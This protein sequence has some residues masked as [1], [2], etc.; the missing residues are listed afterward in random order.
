MCEEKRNIFANILLCDN[1]CCCH[2]QLN[3]YVVAVAVTQFCAFDFFVV[4][5][6]LHLFFCFSAFM[7]VLLSS[8]TMGNMD[9]TNDNNN[10]S[11]HLQWCPPAAA[12]ATATATAYPNEFAS[13]WTTNK[14]FVCR[15]CFYFAYSLTLFFFRRRRRMHVKFLR[16]W[17]TIMI[18]VTSCPE[19]ATSKLTVP[20][21]WCVT[22]T[23]ATRT[24]LSDSMDGWLDDG[25]MYI[26][27]NVRSN[28]RERERRG[29]HIVNKYLVF[30]KNVDNLLALL[31][32][33]FF[34]LLV[35]VCTAMYF[36]LVLVLFTLTLLC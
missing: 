32:L 29:R 33:L 31:L 24:L 14:R 27:R 2:M 13:L 16:K 19:V 5:L 26:C 36:V 10:S 9:D 25:G 8:H 12:A 20:L 21:V 4:L 34:L 6:F 28:S 1:S 17:I 18:N 30:Y 7:V 23:A 35:F 3:S 22:T 11:I 15:C